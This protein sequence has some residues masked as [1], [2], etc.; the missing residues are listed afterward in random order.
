MKYSLISYMHKDFDEIWNILN[1]FRLKYFL[2]DTI[3]EI[4][5][6]DFDAMM[7]EIAR[8]SQ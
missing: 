7:D 8:F 3:A 1:T 4:S 6:N 5:V 2:T